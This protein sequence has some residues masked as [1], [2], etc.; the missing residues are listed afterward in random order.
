MKKL[1]RK[2]FTL[3]ELLVVLVI[4]VVI[5]TI[6]IPSVTSSIE[7]S[8]EKQTSSKIE[9]VLSSA[10][11]YVDIHKNTFSDNSIYI[12]KVKDII[13][14]NLLTKEQAKDPRN[15]KYTLS[16]YVS[17][18]RNDNSYTWVEMPNN[19]EYRLEMATSLSC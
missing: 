9:L 14:D 8:K 6:A 18:N 19:D 10:E 4:L 12:I 15:E 17:Y 2:G 7:R 13:C 3:V 11:L 5:M 16:G 1:D